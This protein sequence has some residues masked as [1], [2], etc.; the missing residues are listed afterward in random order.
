MSLWYSESLIKMLLC[1]TGT[2]CG[3]LTVVASLTSSSNS[4]RAQLQES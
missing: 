1:R 3:Q 2:L 4:L